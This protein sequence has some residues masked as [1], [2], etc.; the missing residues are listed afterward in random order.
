MR[1]PVDISKAT[2]L[3]NH[4]PTT[5]VTSS[6]DGKRNIMAAAWTTIVDTDPGRV[7]VVVDSHT[8]T[9][10]LI[11]RSGS[12][13]LQLPCVAQIDIAYQVGCVSGRALDKI[14]QLGIDTFAATMIAAPLVTGCVAWLECKMIYDPPVPSATSAALPLHHMLQHYDLVVADIIAAQAD[15]RVFRDGKWTF[16]EQHQELRTIHHSTQGL[17]FATGL[18]LQAQLP[19][20]PRES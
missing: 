17:F 15:S 5:L 4:G 12:F 6:H 13:A 8:Y 7:V 9:R 16:D 11:E 18:G 14:D 10:E 19:V 3:L 2:R 20:E 1:V